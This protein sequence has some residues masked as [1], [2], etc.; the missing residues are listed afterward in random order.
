ME[1]A[2]SLTPEDLL[3]LV[4]KQAG[5]FKPV[6]RTGQSDANVTTFKPRSFHTT[7]DEPRP[8]PEARAPETRAPE[9][10]PDFASAPPPKMIDLEAERSAAFAAGLAQA[11]ADHAA[12]IEA[13]RAAARREA[14]AAVATEIADLRHAFEATLTRLT[15][16]EAETTTRLQ[17]QITQAVRQLAAERAGQKIDECPKPFQRRVEKLV[18][19]IAAGIDGLVIR[20]NTAD[21]MAI[22]P[23]I[24][25]FSPL[26]VARLSP[27]PQLGRGDLR[28]VMQ[29][30]S[31]TDCIAPRSNGG[32]S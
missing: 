6:D 26:A 9:P 31:F 11:K 16:I 27:D 32:L 30:I 29:E 3:A 17:D 1:T 19:D 5:R 25:D 8:A 10:P 21:L 20:M 24:K 4:R 18:Q 23:H 7:P 13:E 28:L 14:E 15:T 2:K 12:A 22:R